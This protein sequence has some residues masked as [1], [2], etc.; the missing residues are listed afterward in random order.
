MSSIS[1]TDGQD[2]A[3]PL[4][5]HLVK[6][7]RVADQPRPPVD[8]QRVATTGDEEVQSHVRVAQD[9]L[10]AVGALVAR[11]LGDRDGAL[12]DDVDQSPGGSPLGRRRSCPRRRRWPSRR[13]ARPRASP[14]PPRAVRGGP[15]WPPAHGEP[16]GPRAP[17]RSRSRSRSGRGHASSVGAKELLE[18]AER[19]P[20]NVGEVRDVRRGSVIWNEPSESVSQVDSLL[21]A[22]G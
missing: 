19:E 6:E 18:R 2:R 20:R 21:A 3:V 17:R 22:A 12:V 8:P 15:C 11:P 16:A 4:D 13:T 7:R 5:H 9:V 10:V 1:T 14:G